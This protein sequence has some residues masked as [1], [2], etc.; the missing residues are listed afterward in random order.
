MSVVSDLLGKL[1][2]TGGTKPNPVPLE[3][4][5]K[6]IRNSIPKIHVHVSRAWYTQHNAEEFQRREL[7]RRIF[8]QAAVG[9]AAN[10]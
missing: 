6:S 7:A 4:I 9:I 1:K 3:P 5:M 2:L 8:N 10:R